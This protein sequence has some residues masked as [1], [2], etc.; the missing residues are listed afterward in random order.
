M[1]DHE[2]SLQPCL[3]ARGR[4]DV[5]E[6]KVEELAVADAKDCFSTSYIALCHLFE[7]LKRKLGASKQLVFRLLLAFG[8]VPAFLGEDLS[9]LFSKLQRW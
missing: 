3:V 6:E 4:H 5:H 8:A 2:E 9:L 7:L 1:G